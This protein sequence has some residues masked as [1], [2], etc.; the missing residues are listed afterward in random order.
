MT[1]Q[2]DPP[3]CA[4]LLQ[5]ERAVQFGAYRDKLNCAGR[6]GHQTER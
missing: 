4:G 2:N 5:S 6:N 3:N 1:A